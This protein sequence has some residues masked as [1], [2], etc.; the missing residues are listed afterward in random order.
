MFKKIY[1]LITLVF[2][3]FLIL[4]SCTEYKEET[5]DLDD[6]LQSDGKY[7]WVGYATSKRSN[8]LEYF[9]IKKPS[10]KICIRDMKRHLSGNDGKYYKEPMGCGYMGNNKY[11]SLFMFI[12]VLEKDHFSCLL[13]INNQKMIDVSAK[14][15]SI[16][17]IKRNA[18]YDN[19]NHKVFWSNHETNNLPYN[20][21]SA[22]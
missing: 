5:Y 9:L 13:E 19:K 10:Y 12:F 14:F 16:L 6:Q 22:P 15:N 17:N 7:R 1:P 21:F 8:E 11:L 20:T 3:P 4:T 18:C 2:F